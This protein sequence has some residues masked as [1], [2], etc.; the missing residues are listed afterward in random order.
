MQ[1]GAHRWCGR[2]SA[3]A[4][5]S[6]VARLWPGLPFQFPRPDSGG[7]IASV[8]CKEERVIIGRVVLLD[9]G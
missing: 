6:I 1:E 8:C 5:T 3:K 9:F 7:L 2:E 4:K